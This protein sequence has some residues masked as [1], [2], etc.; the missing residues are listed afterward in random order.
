MK[1]AS[2]SC[3]LTQKVPQDLN[4][5]SVVAANGTQPTL[6]LLCLSEWLVGVQML[7]LKAIL[8]CPPLLDPLL[9]ASATLQHMQ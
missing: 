3:S 2:T 4:K 8:L 9:L 6:C 1:I 5:P 7:S